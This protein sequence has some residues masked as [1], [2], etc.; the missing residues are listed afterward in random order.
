MNPYRS[1]TRAAIRQ[2]LRCHHGTGRAREHRTAIAAI[3]GPQQRKPTPLR[4]LGKRG[5]VRPRGTHPHRAPG[6]APH[7]IAALRRPVP[8]EPD[9]RRSDARAGPRD[10]HAV[11][12]TVAQAASSCD[13]QA[14]S[15]RLAR[16]ESLRMPRFATCRRRRQRDGQHT[17][18]GVWARL[19]ATL[20]H[21]PATSVQNLSAC[22]RHRKYRCGAGARLRGA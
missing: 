22:R 2:V 3:R 21:A 12:V 18:T 10:A 17:S 5:F 6:I 15:A 7:A 13:G 8:A 20:P 14:W 9:T 1:V 11:R 19:R 4:A 16:P